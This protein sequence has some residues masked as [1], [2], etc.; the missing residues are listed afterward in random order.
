MIVLPFQVSRLCHFYSFSKFPQ[1]ICV[2]PIT[3]LTFETLYECISGQNNVSRT[4]FS[5]HS[6][7]S[8]GP[9]I[10]FYVLGL[11]CVMYIGVHPITYSLFMISTCSFIGICIT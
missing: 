11:F 3:L 8:Y 6:F 9:L 4:F 1:K 2:G 7:L 10:M 5:F